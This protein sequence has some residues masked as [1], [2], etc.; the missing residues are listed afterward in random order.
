ML[1]IETKQK[2]KRVL[3]NPIY[4]N[5]RGY[6]DILV[7]AIFGIACYLSFESLMG[8]ILKAAT[9]LCG[10][11]KFADDLTE[12]DVLEAELWH[13]TKKE[14]K[15][16]FDGLWILK[17]RVI[18]IEAKNA[19]NILSQDQ[20]I[21]YI[22][23]GKTKLYTKQN[24]TLWLLAV[25][26]GSANIISS[27]KLPD[28]CNLLYIEWSTIRDVL[29]NQ[30][31][32]SKDNN[33]KRALN[34]LII[35][36]SNRNLKSFSAFRWPSDIKPLADFGRFVDSNSKWFHYQKIIWPNLPQRSI[37]EFDFMF[38]NSIPILFR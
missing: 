30:Y 24:N 1:Q 11:N 21:N 10:S 29:K 38:Q 16:E 34:D 12:D 19:K 33:I 8:P 25:A 3:T 35:F 14:L 37:I 2:L 32:H 27:I 26:K 20:I 23:I 22:N 13:K 36:L 28:N 7:S 4:K 31:T 18:I 5:W 9:P 17:D 15:Y 6:E